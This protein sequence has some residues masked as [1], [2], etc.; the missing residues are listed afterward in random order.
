M[1]ITIHNNGLY[2]NKTKTP[3]GPWPIVKCQIQLTV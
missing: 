3:Y 1:L 2:K